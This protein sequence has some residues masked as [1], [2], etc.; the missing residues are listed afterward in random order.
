MYVR[1]HIALV[2]TFLTLC[3]IAY[4]QE[5]KDSVK[6][7]FRQGSAVLDTSIGNNRAALRRI[8]DS[9]AVSYSDSLYRYF[10]QEV[11]VIGGASPRVAWS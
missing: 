8:A 5:V 10:L 1:K 7:Y 9:L 6:I 2:I 11:T 4:G 3:C